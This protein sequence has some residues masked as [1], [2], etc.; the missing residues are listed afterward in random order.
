MNTNNKHARF[1]RSVLLI[2]LFAVFSVDG[3]AYADTVVSGTISD[4]TVWNK[5]ESPYLVSELVD[6]PA[7]AT[8]TIEPGTVVKLGN[9][10]ASI[11]VEGT[12]NAIG[13]ETDPITF[14]S[15]YDDTIGGDTDGGDTDGAGA[16]RIPVFSDWLGINFQNGSGAFS[17]I[18]FRYSYL[19][20]TSTPMTIDHA[21]FQYAELSVAGPAD[22]SVRDSLFEDQHGVSI[23]LR[24]GVTATID[25]VT[26][27]RSN[28]TGLLING[29]V[30]TLSNSSITD[31]KKGELWN[32]IQLDE[33]A[34]LSMNT[35]TLDGGSTGIKLFGHN[36]LHISDAAI[37]HF[38]N[39]GIYQE[40]GP[41]LMRSDSDT[42][43]MIQLA[44]EIDSQ[45]EITIIRTEISE[46]GTGIDILS[47]VETSI[48]QNSIHGNEL[49]VGGTH[50]E[51][52][53]WGDS[54]GPNDPV[55]NPNGL[56]DP[57]SE[58]VQ[59]VPWLTVDPLH[60]LV[61]TC[62]SN[63]AFLPGIEASRLYSESQKGANLWEPFGN[64]DVRK[65]FL[66]AQGLSIDKSIYTGDIIDRFKAFGINGP[67]IYGNFMKTMDELAANGTIAS[68]KSFSYDWRQ[69]VTDIVSKGVKTKNDTSD[70]VQQI[71]TLA[72]SSKTDKV[73][74]IAHSNGGLATKA[75]ML[76]LLSEGKA[77]L[78][79]KIIFVAVPQLG[80]PDA[81]NVLLH[82]MSI[83]KLGI[84][85]SRPVARSLAENMPGI[86]GLLPSQQYFEA[87]SDPVI[88]FDQSVGS[89]G[90]FL[91]KY[92]TS[93]ASASKLNDFLLGKEG[94]KKPSAENANKPNVVNASLLAQAKAMRQ[95]LDTWRPPSGVELVQLAGRGISTI[96]GIAYS[97]VYPCTKLITIGLCTPYLDEKPLRTVNGDKT[98]VYPSAI[99]TDAK[100]YFFDLAAYNDAAKKNYDHKNILETQPVLQ[101]LKQQLN[102]EEIENQYIKES[103]PES[104]VLEDTIAISI[105]S[106]ASIDLYDT[107]GNHT[108]PLSNQ[109]NSDVI[110]YEENIPNSYY[111]EFGEGKYAGAPADILRTIQIQGTGAGTFT[112]VIDHQKGDTVMKTERFADIPVTPNTKASVTFTQNTGSM[113][114]LDVDGNGTNDFSIQP[115]GNA[116]DDSLDPVLFLQI[117]KQT[118]HLLGL[119]PKVEQVLQQKIDR[120]IKLTTK[121]KKK[122]LSAFIKQF[123]RNVYEKKWKQSKKLSQEQKDAL[124][125]MVINFLSTI[126]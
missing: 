99:A 12:V 4:G 21:H 56:G 100:K 90:N 104:G 101:F 43:S 24:P 78:V 17:H 113:L 25:N 58:G 49:G 14:T 15:W 48:Q 27:N 63:I 77:N 80:T 71:E 76:R 83:P 9:G 114:T 126:Q 18:N 123:S 2:A 35:T 45:P 86:Y 115:T 93:I 120:V 61:S 29:S 122:R 82:G 92:G 44:S 84:I 64:A 57:V 39:A 47:T 74:I 55:E 10:N 1:V 13:T 42:G 103:Y 96:K 50:F 94:R 97:A 26:I 125:Q 51:N 3:V 31:T 8:L 70:M 52:N 73:T 95:V 65:L 36:T 68:W 108:G 22:L 19:T 40:I 112:L 5:S 30:V 7:G 118:V 60:V 37:K 89:V 102:E 32:A 111:D 69:S 59:Y 91:E 119:P 87:I 41:V 34:T 75:L 81:V 72:S 46:N 67:S 28:R 85:M 79:D 20:G 38:T 53:W 116:A 124:T 6:V 11:A 88:T 54:S 66:D 106:P 33:N 117:M 107:A 62:C 121:D 110:L 98:L 109:S 23:E 16:P 105:H